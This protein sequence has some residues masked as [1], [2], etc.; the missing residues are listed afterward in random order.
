MTRTTPRLSRRTLLAA[1]LVLAATQVRAEKKYGPGVTDTEIKIGNTVPYSGN[2][3]AYGQN[4]RAAAAYFR[5]INDQ[6][7]VNGRKVTFISLDDGYSPPKTVELVRQLVEREQVLLMFAPLGT[8]P[9]IA[10][11][12]YL[13]QKKVPQLFVAT[14]ASRWGDPQHF[15]WTMGWQPDYRTEG[16]IYAKHMLGTVK[17]PKIA[18]LRQNDDFGMDYLNGFRQGLGKNADKLIAM[19]ATYEVTDPTV[20]SQVIQLKNTGANVFFNITTP[21]F[22]AQAIKKAAEI[23][24]KPTQYLVNV[25]ASIGAAIK[26]A[27]FENAQGIITAQYLKDVTDPRWEGEADFKAWKE[28]MAKWNSTA[29]PLEGAN[30]SGYANAFTM[31]QV[32]KQCGDDLTRENVMRQAANLHDLAVPMLLPGIKVNTSPTDFYP[33]KA[34]HPARL[35]GEHWVLFGELLSRDSV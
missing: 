24:W 10:I 19:E 34:V 35:D 14:G 22:A 15:P 27:G 16:A 17:E 21:K 2:A 12:K 28:W 9:N 11:Q 23:G 18:I 30:A 8:A 31:T 1:P 32:L 13:N 4:G 7:G 29:N 3:S 20:D 25:A 6:G 33:I 26:P 5:M